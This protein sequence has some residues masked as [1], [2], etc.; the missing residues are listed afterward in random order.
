MKQQQVTQVQGVVVAVDCQQAGVLSIRLDTG[1]V[2]VQRTVVGDVLFAQLR[3]LEAGTRL[4]AVGVTR[5]GLLGSYLDARRVSVVGAEAR[6]RTEADKA[7]TAEQ[8][9]KVVQWAHKLVQDPHSGLSLEARA[10]FR[11]MLGL[12]W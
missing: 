12:T 5:D 2:N 9:A 1:A 11:A 3:L 8:W 4:T 6:V 7:K 10:E